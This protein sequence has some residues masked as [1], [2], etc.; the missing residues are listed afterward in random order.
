MLVPHCS[1]DPTTLHAQP[2]D[3]RVKGT[4]HW[5]SAA[6]ARPAEMRLYDLLFSTADP[7]AAEG[8]FTDHLRPD[9]LTTLRGFVE[10]SV[11]QDSPGARY[12]FERLGYF[13]Q[14]PEGSQPGELG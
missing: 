10:P 4:I 5:V 7:D 6:H 8:E 12:Q 13:L 11:L 14:N 2:A 3:G 1:Y 9:S